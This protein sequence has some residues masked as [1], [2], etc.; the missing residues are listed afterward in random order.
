LLD[1]LNIDKTDL[2]QQLL[3]K[4]SPEE[5]MICIAVLGSERADAGCAVNA[6]AHPQGCLH[7]ASDINRIAFKAKSGPIRAV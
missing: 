5:T 3:Q 2:M 6:A 7:A 4:R 1:A